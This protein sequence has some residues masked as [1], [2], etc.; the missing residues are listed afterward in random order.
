MTE[1]SSADFCKLTI[2]EAADLLADKLHENKKDDSKRNRS[3]M[4]LYGKVDDQLC[5][6]YIEMREVVE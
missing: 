3:R 6:I 4:R 2:Q 1:L 5:E